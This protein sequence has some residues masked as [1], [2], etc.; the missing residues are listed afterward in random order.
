[1][2]E[3]KEREN[4]R[5]E[6][7]E[8]DETEDSSQ[9]AKGAALSCQEESSK[10]DPDLP[11]M[12]WEALSLR[13]AELEKQEEEKRERLKSAGGAE[14]GSMSGGWGEERDGGS[15]WEDV[16]ADRSR[17]ITALT[18]RFH[19]Q[20]NLQLCFINDSES[21]DE[22][23]KDE[24]ASG[25]G[26][27]GSVSCGRGQS[28]QTSPLMVADGAGRTRGLKL[29]V[30]AALSALRD[31]LW[32]EQKEERLACQGIEVKRKRL[33]LSDL[34]TL[35]LQQL[36]SLRESLNQAVHDLSSELVNRLLT[37]DQLRTE[38]DAM[39]MDVEDMTSL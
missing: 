25:E 6:E 36:D 35:N 1:M 15:W 30:R 37:R 12:H 21:E 33:D 19:N 8:N 11:I 20:K 17:R 9:A 31:K 7:K 38:Q 34:Q 22:D 39:L 2:E 24:E 13:I 10:G 28:K 32:T 18:S 27:R 14:Q 16:E 5:E 26:P 23:E 29:E 4:E 3:Q